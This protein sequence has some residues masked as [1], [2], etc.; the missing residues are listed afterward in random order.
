MRKPKLSVPI[1][2]K[3][4]SFYIQWISDKYGNFVKDKYYKATAKSRHGK[5]GMFCD[6][7]ITDEDGDYYTLD[8]KDI[9]KKFRIIPSGE[10][11]LISEPVTEKDIPEKCCCNCGHCLRIPDVENPNI[12]SHN[13]CEVDNHYIGYVACFTDCCKYWTPDKFMLQE[14]E[15]SCINR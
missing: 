12:I 13:K 1:K 8:A 3:R 14:K 6:F 4:E 11:I 2:D 5:S 10:V 7:R 15:E 9:E